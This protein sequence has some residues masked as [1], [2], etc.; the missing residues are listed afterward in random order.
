MIRADA[1]QKVRAYR[2]YFYNTE[3]RD[4]W[5]RLWQIGRIYQL[6]QPL[7]RY[8]VH[9]GSVSR[10]KRV[11]QLISHMMA[12][13]SA[14]CR[15]LQLDDQP[16]LDRSLTMSD[17]H[18]ALDG[19]A[20]LIGNRY[21]VDKYRWYHC[22]R[23]RMWRQAPFASRSEMLRKVVACATRRPFD[24]ASL[25]LLATAVRHGPAAQRAETSR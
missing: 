8:R 2:P 9:A 3:D 15:H 6:P 7:L 16:I 21:P 5:A 19:Y 12:D 24:R 1:L 25:K 22:I 10:Q 11:D 18:E 20:V 4:L 23:N 13:M 17:R 14:L